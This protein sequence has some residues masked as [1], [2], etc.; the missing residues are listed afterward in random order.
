MS[1]PYG[2]LAEP[3]Q[4]RKT[5]GRSEQSSDPAPRPL[6]GSPLRI[7]VACVRGRAYVLR[8]QVL[9]DGPLMGPPDGAHLEHSNA[10]AF[11][12]AFGRP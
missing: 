6:G 8:V 11:C 3:S 5:A 10:Q 1:C 2:G 7:S 4:N 9:C 12:Q